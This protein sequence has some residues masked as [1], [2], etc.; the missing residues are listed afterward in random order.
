MIFLV[1]KS[2]ELFDRDEY[3]IISVQE[4]LDIMRTWNTV[5]FDTEGTGLDCHIAKMLSMQFGNWDKS[6]QIV[7]DV[8]TVSP[9][10]Y[11]EILENKLLIGH[12][13]KY[14]TKM[15]MAV[16]I[17]PTNVYDTMIAEQLRYL[18]Y[19]SGMYSM[20]LKEVAHRYLDVSMDKSVRGKIKYVGLTPEVIVYGAHDVLYLYDIMQK[21]VEYFM[22]IGA[23]KALQIECLF[24]IPC[25]YFEYCGVK[26]DEN[27]WLEMYHR[28]KKTLAEV[29]KQLN[30][31]VVNL[32]NRKF[33]RNYVQLDLFEQVDTSSKCNIDWNS[34]DSVIPLLKYLGFDTKG[35][36]KKKKEEKESKE[37]KL[38]EKQRKIN[39]EFVDLY[40]KYS[41]YNKLVTTYGMQYINAINP[42]TGRIHT[43][44]RALGTDTGRLACGSQKINEELAKLKSLPVKKI[45]NRPD[46]VCAYPQIQNLPKDAEVRACFIA[47]KGNDF[48][49]ID[50]NSEES[51]LL[52]SLSG[53]KNM[54]EVFKEGY[55]M[56]SYVAYLIYPDKIP[57]DIDIK[58]IKKEYHDL[59]QQA[60]G[61]EFTFAF[62]G[63]WA[64]LV[65]NYGMPP[66]EAKA[67]ER[68][69]KEGFKQATIYQEKCKK[70]TESTGII[71]ICKETGHVAHWWDWD[72]WNKIQHS[73]EFW[74]EYKERKEAGLPRT[75]EA[76]EHFA[77]RNKWDKNAVNST[78][79]G[80]GAVI[81]KGFSYRFLMWILQNNLFNKVKFCVPV[82]DEICIE[83]PKEYTSKVVEKLKFFMED[84]GA[85]YCHLLPL[86]A[87]AEIS[88]HWVH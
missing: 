7:V 76:S 35:Y 19:P 62:L 71:R 60:K 20:S 50:Y 21:Q 63:N 29:T 87:E 53:D 5:Q 72:K 52:A 12:N 41:K 14:D 81:F 54:L 83:C 33:I 4:S 44:F 30:D 70:Y 58:R 3:K 17:V 39:P 26:L 78:T 51:R 34:T 73:N 31:F 49:S 15:L 55:D 59:R 22:S 28:N 66:E 65:A 24:T 61:P 18:A 82:H 57:R 25:A 42:K 48:V 88:D 64:T 67:I 16:G 69:Y 56:H 85:K 8:T 27:H 43:E 40:V 9:L 75:D 32:G 38:I 13:L 23:T 46:L 80:L 10:K 1:T 6:V 79:Q 84:E 45:T 74:Q 77:A 11:K 36:D 86:P 68:N 2:H 47:E 37:T